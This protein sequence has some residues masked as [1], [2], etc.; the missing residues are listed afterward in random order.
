M[1]KTAA[2]TASRLEVY[3]LFGDLVPCIAF[4]AGDNQ[5]VGIPAH[6][7]LLVKHFEVRLEHFNKLLFKKSLESLVDFQ[8][9]HS[10]AVFE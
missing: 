7:S 3:F 6:L 2:F 8:E 10:H 9:F 5:E 4:F 1:K